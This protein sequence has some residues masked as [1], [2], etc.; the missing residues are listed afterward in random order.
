MSGASPPASR[1]GVGLGLG[2][3]LALS[4]GGWSGC[5]DQANEVHLY[6][7]VLDAGSAKPAPLREGE[8]L[9]LER[10]LA[11][12]NADNEQ[13]AS[14]GETYLQALIEKR[15][16]FAAYLPTVN[17]QPSYTI[18]QAPRGTVQPLTAGAPAENAAAVAAT[19]GNFAQHGNVLTRLEAPLVGNL[20]FDFRDM[21][22][23]R[24]AGVVVAQQKQ[25]LL[26][27]R[28][29]VLL[30]VAQT[31]Y[32]V[33]VATAQEAVLR[34]SLQLQQARVRDLEARYR[35]RLA[36]SLDVA[37]AR[38]DEAATR[39]QLDQAGNTQRNARRMLALLIG[40]PS[41]TGPLDDAVIAPSPLEPPDRYARRADAQR[42]DLLAAKLA[43]QAAHY[44]VDAAVA[45]Y[46]PSA[47]LN[48]AGYLYEQNYIDASKWNGILLVNLPIF[49]AGTIQADVRESWSR[50]RQAAL[51]ESYLRREIDQGVR[52]AYDNLV[53]SGDQ[54]AELRQEVT[55]ADEAYVQAVQMERKGLAIPLDVLTAQDRLLNAQLQWTQEAFNQT[56]DRLNLLRAVEGLS[57]ATPRQFRW[58]APAE[59]PGAA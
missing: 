53:T 17:F 9:T 55:A 39:V 21:P 14:Q 6:R 49:S 32:Q 52:T 25:L 29:T 12:A 45:E 58:V 22:L 3:G 1:L 15:R 7:E 59:R 19:Q 5:V 57:P 54:L 41:V 11:L 43:V 50:L 37:Q 34:H 47:S 23:Y 31:Y 4:L 48:V 20:N 18:E 27:T 36:L 38:S 35:V 16:A 24:G 13:L 42:Q 10:A 2:V 40:A 28:S 44:A 56:I 51:F 46:Y 8:T 30:N 26:D 33:I